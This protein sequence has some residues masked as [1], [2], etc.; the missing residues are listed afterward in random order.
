QP[1]F[2]QRALLLLHKQPGNKLPPPQNWTSKRQLL[3]RN[4]QANSFQFGV[5]LDEEGPEGIVVSDVAALQASRVFFQQV[6]QHG[7]KVEYFYQNGTREREEFI[8]GELKR[9]GIDAVTF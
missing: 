4:G 6:T 7:W 5:I 1:R 2:Q 9:K 3:I 8:L